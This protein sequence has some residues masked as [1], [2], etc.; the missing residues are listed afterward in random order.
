MKKKYNVGAVGES[1]PFKL[2]EDSQLRRSQ[3]IHYII[4]VLPP[5]LNPKK[6]DMMTDKHKA[7]RLLRS[8]W[9]NTLGK[10]KKITF[11]SLYS[12]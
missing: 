8:T 7:E 5:N 2:P 12:Y 1:Y 3:N 11:F 4:H 10:K 9:N 6:P